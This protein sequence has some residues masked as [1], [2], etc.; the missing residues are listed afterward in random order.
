MIAS[1][2]RPN[3]DQRSSAELDRGFRLDKITVLI[4]DDSPP[5]MD[6]LRRILRP[7]PEVEVIGE[8]TSGSEAILMAGELRPP[9]GAEVPLTVVLRHTDRRWPRLCEDDLEAV[10]GLVRGLG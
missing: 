3:I 6:G 4:V 2:P 9:R 7:C 8:A 5:A 10:E 1:K